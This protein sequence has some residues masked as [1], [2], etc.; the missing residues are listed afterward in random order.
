MYFFYKEKMDQE[1]DD[2]DDINDIDYDCADGPSIDMIGNCYYKSK[3]KKW[4]TPIIDGR[5]VTEYDLHLDRDFAFGNEIALIKK[6]CTIFFRIHSCPLLAGGGELLEI[7]DKGI[8]F[9]NHKLIRLLNKYFNEYI[10]IAISSIY[11]KEDIDK[12][13]NYVLGILVDI[14]DNIQFN[15]AK[16]INKCDLIFPE[17]CCAICDYFDISANVDNAFTLILEKF[18]LTVS[19]NTSFINLLFIRVIVGYMCVDDLHKPIIAY[20]SLSLL[21]Q[22]PNK[23]NKFV[24]LIITGIFLNGV[25]DNSDKNPII[26]NDIDDFKEMFDFLSNEYVDAQF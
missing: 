8:Y 4:I 6:D 7:T 11:Y 5:R 19:N 12:Y 1:I 2:I 3:T 13:F 9:N 14:T 10:K 16:D 20:I 24:N 25:W 17:F 15:G 26:V 22:A 23:K 21:N 18:N